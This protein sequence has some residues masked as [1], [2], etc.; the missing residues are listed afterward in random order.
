[1]NAQPPFQG[2]SGETKRFGSALL[3]FLSC[4][5]ATALPLQNGSFETGGV[6]PCNTFNIP[7]GSTL[8]TGWTVSAGNIDWLGAP[9]PGLRLAGV[10]GQQ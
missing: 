8:I 5:L 10:S 9:G 6:V 2:A 4:G 7:T 3:L 1:L